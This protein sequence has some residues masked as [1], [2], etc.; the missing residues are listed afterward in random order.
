MFICE[1]LKV[2]EFQPPHTVKK[3]FTSAFQSFYTS[4]GSSYSKA[5]MY[6]KSLKIICEEVLLTCKLRKKNSFTH[7]PSCILPS[8]S[9]NT[10]D[11]FSEEAL[12]VCEH[13]SFQEI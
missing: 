6:L 12:K 4:R 9:Q 1:F 3:Y 11:Y 5:L 13:N 7:P 8:F 2:P 10:H